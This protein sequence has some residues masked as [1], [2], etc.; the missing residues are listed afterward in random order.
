M[1][2]V[3]H[4]TTIRSAFSFIIRSWSSLSLGKK[5]QALVRMI[6]R[7]LLLEWRGFSDVWMDFE[8]KFWWPDSR[9]ARVASSLSLTMVKGIIQLGTLKIWPFR[10][11]RSVSSAVFRIWKSV[12]R[13]LQRILF[14][15][16]ILSPNIQLSVAP[17][18][19]LCKDEEFTCL[20]KRDKT[21]LWPV[22]V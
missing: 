22:E 18:C 7:K 11:R 13:V 4:V 15:K 12:I 14:F 20:V 19:L 16:E 9:L 17:V 2:E 21:W 1:L 5:K 8:R 10:I 6:G 3:N